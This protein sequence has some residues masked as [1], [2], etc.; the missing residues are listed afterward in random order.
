[1]LTVELFSAE[2]K[3]TVYGCLFVDMGQGLFIFQVVIGSPCC[4]GT[5]LVHSQ[6]ACEMRRDECLLSLSKYR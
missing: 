5:R 3:Q 1:M 4:V 6:L 2:N